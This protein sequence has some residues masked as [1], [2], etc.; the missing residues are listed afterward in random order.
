M[1]TISL[2]IYPLSSKP[3]VIVSQLTHCLSIVYTPQSGPIW[4]PQTQAKVQTLR[5]YKKCLEKKFS[6]PS[7]KASTSKIIKLPTI[8]ESTFIKEGSSY[9]NHS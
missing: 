4:K 6:N 2:S 8:R 3:L 9:S 5:F 7:T 1:A